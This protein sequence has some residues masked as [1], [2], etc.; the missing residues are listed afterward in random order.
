MPTPEEVNKS[1]QDGG[2]QGTLLKNEQGL[3]GQNIFEALWGDNH[4]K[5]LPANESIEING[6]TYTWD[7]FHK[8]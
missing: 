1:W 2:L 7:D 3:T 4:D 8:D 6:T 5:G